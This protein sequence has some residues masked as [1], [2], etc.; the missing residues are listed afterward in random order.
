MPRGRGTVAAV[1][2]RGRRPKSCSKIVTENDSNVEEKYRRLL[3]PPRSPAT[4][5]SSAVPAAAKNRID[6]RVRPAQYPFRPNNGVG[7]STA[8]SKGQFGGER[9]TALA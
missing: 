3:P 6:P 2:G 9:A 4:R 7:A 8:D 1:P 5:A